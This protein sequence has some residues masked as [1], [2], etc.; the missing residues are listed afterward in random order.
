MRRTKTTERHFVQIAVVLP[1]VLFWLLS[2]PSFAFAQQWKYALLVGPQSYPLRWGER[3][4]PEE[5]M[6]P[7]PPGL[8]TSRTIPTAPGCFKVNTGG[9]YLA[10]EVLDWAWQGTLVIVARDL[11]TG[12]ILWQRTYNNLPRWGMVSLEGF[13]L[14]SYITRVGFEVVRSGYLLMFTRFGVFVVLDEPKPPMS[15]AWVSV[16]NI[17]C[18]WARGESTPDG[19]AAALTQKLWENGRYNG[20][21]T[22]YTRF[23]CD[24]A[25]NI[26]SEATEYFYLKRFIE[27]RFYGQCNDFADFLVCLITSVGAFQATAQRT[28]PL[29]LGYF[30]TEIIDPAGPLPP[31]QVDWNYHQFCYY[32]GNVWDGCLAFVSGSPQG[33]PKKLPRDTTYYDGLVAYYYYGQWQPSPSNGFIPGVYALD[34]PQ[35]CSPTNPNAP[36]GGAGY[37]PNCPSP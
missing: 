24:G 2:F 27:G 21:Y 6:V 30:R 5:D 12:D 23:V 17:S 20:G 36:C 25:G 32:N 3:E 1:A 37:G 9:F 34:L 31:Q 15:P 16:L 18:D 35:T 8:D 28:H 19:A 33:P 11:A 4:P 26:P 14:P 10:Y 13:T 7:T 29:G 22:A